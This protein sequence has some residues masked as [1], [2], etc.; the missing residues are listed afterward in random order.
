MEKCV[1][2]EDLIFDTWTDLEEGIIQNQCAADIAF[3]HSTLTKQFRGTF[4][5]DTGW[6]LNHVS[7]FISITQLL[8]LLSISKHLKCSLQEQTKLHLNMLSSVQ[9]TSQE[10]VRLCSWFGSP[11][12]AGGLT[13]DPCRR[14]TDIAIKTLNLSKTNLSFLC[15][16]DCSFL[17]DKIVHLVLGFE[18]EDCTEC[19]DKSG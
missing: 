4:P 16:S 12:V 9:M 13:L 10:F 18:A 1:K 14:H 6:L 7:R 2:P 11:L 15:M 8:Q 5:L 3:C 17:N 19:K